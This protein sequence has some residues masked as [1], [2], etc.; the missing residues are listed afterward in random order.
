MTD[1]ELKDEMRQDKMEEARVETEYERCMRE[2]F[3]YA[4]EQ[5]NSQYDL[6]EAIET[7]RTVIH[8]L[9]NYGHYITANDLLNL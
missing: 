2:D 4:L 8:E 3:D 1:Q 7:I 6:Y 9:N 5:M